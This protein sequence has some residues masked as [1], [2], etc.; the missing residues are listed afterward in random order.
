MST[1]DLNEIANNP[2][3]KLQI[4]S[5]TQEDPKDA[6]IRRAKDIVLFVVAVLLILSA[7]VFCGYL[8][9]NPS[10]TA[11]DKKWATVIAG[12]IISAFLGY[13]TGK[14]FN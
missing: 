12:S 3:L 2:K 8:L 10:S 14:H 9:L 5:I 4:S 6:G 11:D 13:L 7:F 1:I